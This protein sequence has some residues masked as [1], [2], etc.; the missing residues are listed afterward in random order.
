M[1]SESSLKVAGGK[2]VQVKADHDCGRINS[3]K[4]YG[5]F[6][7]HPEDAL[8]K[9]EKKLENIRADDVESI[10]RNF[11]QGDVKAFGVDAESITKV[12]TEAMK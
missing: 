7:M 10:V 4:I 2:L 9:L 5:D 12:I 11:F 3:V 6:F 8:N 1:I